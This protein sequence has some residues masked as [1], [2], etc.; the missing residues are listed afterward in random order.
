MIPTKGEK[1]YH[2]LEWKGYENSG[3]SIYQPGILK[4]FFLVVEEVANPFKNVMKAPGPLF[5]KHI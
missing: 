4:L 1:I 5:R 3:H 2:K